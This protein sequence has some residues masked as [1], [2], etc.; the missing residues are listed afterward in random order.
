MRTLIIP[1]IATWVV[2]CS[3]D[4]VN[5]QNMYSLDKKQREA[6][7]QTANTAV[8]NLGA[9]RAELNAG[10]DGGLSVNQIKEILVHMY[11]YC[12]FPRSLQ[13][14]N[15]FIAVLEERR[16]QGI[17]DNMGKEASPVADSR[18]K[19]IR[20][21]ENLQRLTGIEEKTVSGANAFAPQPY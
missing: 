19:Y 14:I 20:G 6:A 3:M 21:K 12:G 18:D 9:L 11:D 7:D 2:L 4:K 5:S 13:G 10:L 8:G 16:Q 1:I 15:T 17:E